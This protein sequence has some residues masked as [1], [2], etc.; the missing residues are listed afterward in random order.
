MKQFKYLMMI[1]LPILVVTVM[2]QA[3]LQDRSSW[4]ELT[5]NPH[6]Y[7]RMPEVSITPSTP[8]SGWAKVYA[9][10]NDIYFKDDAGVTTSMLG[11]PG[12]TTSASDISITAT[13]T[14]SIDSSDWDI[15]TTGVMT[16]V[17]SVGF[18]SSSVLYQDSVELSNADIK[19][20][21]A[22][23]A[24]LIAAKGADTIIEFVSAVLILDYGSNVLTETDDNLVIEF[25]GGQDV[26]GAI[27]T[28]GFID[29]AVD[30][31]AIVPA[32][33]VA[34]MTA[35]TAVNK[36]IRIFNTGTAEF[37]GNADADTTMTVKVTYRVHAAGL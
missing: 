12:I 37:G 24:T 36:A 28:T 17:A 25:E 29:Q 6:N 3:G 32:A 20:L 13:G 16:G 33:T 30:Q 22:T 5:P 7:V 31:I 8:K 10:A 2:S 35:A 11:V 26:T 34:T 15:S 1:L 18:D 23:P 14:I 21:R 4:I 27:E 19:A 9:A